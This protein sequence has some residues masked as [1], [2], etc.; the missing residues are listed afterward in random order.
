M[1]GKHPGKHP[2]RGLGEQTGEHHPG[3][4]HLPAGN[5]FG[6]HRE[7]PLRVTGNTGG[8]VPKEHPLFPTSD[9]RENNPLVR[10]CAAAVCRPRLASAPS[11]RR[12]PHTWTQEVRSDLRARCARTPSARCAHGVCVRGTGTGSAHLRAHLS[13]HTRSLGHQGNPST[14][15]TASHSLSTRTH[16]AID[17]STPAA[18]EQQ[19]DASAAT[20]DAR[21]AHDADGDDRRR[22][23]RGVTPSPTLRPW[24]SGR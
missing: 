21:D 20:R 11:A 4:S 24:A 22:D 23:G 13:A 10:R 17:L 3:N 5:T 19:E 18:T 12:S 14:L 8:C 6:K 7:T 15:T 1:S 16:K 9:R 2:S